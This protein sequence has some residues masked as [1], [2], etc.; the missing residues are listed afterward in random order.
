MMIRT[1]RPI[2]PDES[3]IEHS[4]SKR[5]V[6]S[7]LAADMT[8]SNPSTALERDPVCG[9][10]VNPASATHVHEYAG[11]KYYFCCASCVERFKGQPQTYVNRPAPL[12]SNLVML[13]TPAPAKSLAAPDPANAHSAASR[14]AA[15]PAATEPGYV[16]P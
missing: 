9:M 3:T 6:P 1:C 10:N 5:T 11:K 14:S 7:A 15:K 12:S 2:P 13:G 16:C 4:Q 8:T